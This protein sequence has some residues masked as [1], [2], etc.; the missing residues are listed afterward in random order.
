MSARNFQTMEHFPLY[1]RDFMNEAEA[2]IV[3]LDLN[4]QLEEFN[5]QLMFHTVSIEDGYYSGVQFYVQENHNP[6]DYD[7]DDCHYY[8]DSYRSVAI[9]RYYS[10]INKINRALR[11]LAKDFNFDEVY[12]SAVF[13]NG[14]ALYA[15][16]SPNRHARACQAVSPVM[17]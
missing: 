13:S 17:G 15:K 14:E 2:D 9:R 10:E 11:M 3:C 12:C 7:N 1:V 6:E 8:F 5:R 4:E 16:V